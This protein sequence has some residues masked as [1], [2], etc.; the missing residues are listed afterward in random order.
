MLLMKKRNCYATVTM[1]RKFAVM[2]LVAAIDCYWIADRFFLHVFRGLWTEFDSTFY[3]NY[4]SGQQIK[5]FYV[6]K[7]IIISHIH[8]ATRTLANE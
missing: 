7:R 8:P 1:I 3:S 4:P 2:W 5:K 6:V